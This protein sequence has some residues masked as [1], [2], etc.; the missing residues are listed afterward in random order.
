MPIFDSEYTDANNDIIGYYDQ[1]Q[2]VAFSLLHR[3]DSENVESVQF[4]WTYTNPELRLGIES[5]KTECALY[6]DR[7]FRYLYLDYAHKYKQS[8]QGFETLGPAE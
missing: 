6:R 7:G 3:F 2:L 1:G 4:A 5:L 8:I